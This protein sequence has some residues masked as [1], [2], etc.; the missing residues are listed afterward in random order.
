MK[1]DKKMIK[2]STILTVM[3]AI[4]VIAT[5]ASAIKATTKASELLDEARKDYPYDLNKIEIIRIIGPT[6]IPTILIGLSTIACIFGANALNKRQ[7]AIMAS[8]YALLNN[9]YNNYREKVKELYGE[10]ANKKVIKELAINSPKKY[11]EPIIASD[12]KKLFFDFNSLQYFE[13]TMDEVLQK[14][15]TDDGSE[16]YIISTPYINCFAI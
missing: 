4:G 3:G 16:C 2:K 7:Q 15:E 10:D 12:E 5:T 6:Y 11:S 14:I 9:S 13:S 1:E 8:S